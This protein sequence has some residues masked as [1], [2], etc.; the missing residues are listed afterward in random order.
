MYNATL[1]NEC[2]ERQEGNFQA[3]YEVLGSQLIAVQDI[4]V[5]DA[6]PDDIKDLLGGALF[7]AL[8]KWMLESGPVYLLPTGPVSSF[9][10][11]SDPAVARHVLQRSDNPKD[12]VYGKGLVAE[13]SEFLFGVGFATAG[14]KRRVPR[15]ARN[16]IRLPKATPFW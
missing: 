11:V 2:F 6:K 7:K 13:V 3:S 9:L 14:M 15:R 4:P 16:P 8:Y 1:G 12:N 5:A 10:V